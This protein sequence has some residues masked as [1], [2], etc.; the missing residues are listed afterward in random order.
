MSSNVNE[1]VWECAICL[2]EEDGR[3]RQLHSCYLHMFHQDCLLEAA[4]RNPACPLCR[5]QA[6]SATLPLVVNMTRHI[7]LQVP[8]PCTVCEDEITQYDVY[9]KF[10][11]C[12]HRIHQRCHD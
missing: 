9:Y 7:G 4:K 6:P 1:D 2:G 12:Q 8:I 5:H 10:V 11:N 3:Q